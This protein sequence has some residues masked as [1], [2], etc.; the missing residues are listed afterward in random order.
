MWI[1][2]LTIAMFDVGMASQLLIWTQ[3]LNLGGQMQWLQIQS[4]WSL[5]TW[6]RWRGAHK[7]RLDIG[8]FQVQNWMWMVAKSLCV[9][10]THFYI[11]SLFQPDLEDKKRFKLPLLLTHYKGCMRS[12]C[13]FLF[14]I[15]LASGAFD[16]PGLPWLQVS[17]TLGVGASFSRC[18]WIEAA[19]EVIRHTWKF[20]KGPGSGMNMW[21]TGYVDFANIVIRGFT[22]L[23]FL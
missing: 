22:F 12:G 11:T 6:Q 2:S 10:N 16:T 20:L 19:T 21:K 1:Q 13:K 4:Y 15:G 3:Q 7:T 8:L 18:A 14:T 17:S 23:W 9:S 5:W